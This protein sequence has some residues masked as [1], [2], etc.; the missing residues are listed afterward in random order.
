MTAG[1]P[2]EQGWRSSTSWSTAPSTIPRLVVVKQGGNIVRFCLGEC[3]QR[4]HI[5]LSRCQQHPLIQRAKARRAS[6]RLSSGARKLLWQL[7]PVVEGNGATN[8]LLSENSVSRAPAA[9]LR[10]HRTQERPPDAHMSR[11]LLA[12]ILL[13]AVG[14]DVTVRRYDARDEICGYAFPRIRQRRSIAPQEH[15]LSPYAGR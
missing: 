5:S 7:L 2:G 11:T 15:A 4:T 6:G 1:V 14:I 13:L 3:F 9:A 10:P 8:S 12:D